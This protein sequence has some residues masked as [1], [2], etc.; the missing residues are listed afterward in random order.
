M[1]D[2]NLPGQRSDRSIAIT[3]MI[4]MMILFIAV[5]CKSW[6]Q[7]RLRRPAQRN[8]RL[9]LSDQIQHVRTP[10]GTCARRRLPFT[11]LQPPEWMGPVQMRQSVSPK[12]DGPRN[13]GASSKFFI[14]AMKGSPMAKQS[15]SDGC[16]PSSRTVRNRTAIICQSLFSD[17]KRV[18]LP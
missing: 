6:R 3:T 14:E 10:S 2:P 7:E 16:E 9:Q 1:D 15:Q 4:A 11:S 12:A 5:S 8:R 13:Y 18:A 17:D